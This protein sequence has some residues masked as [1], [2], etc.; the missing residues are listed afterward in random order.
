MQS[1]RKV[2]KHICHVTPLRL[3]DTVQERYEIA[4]SGW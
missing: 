3:R 1:Y 2:N 4:I